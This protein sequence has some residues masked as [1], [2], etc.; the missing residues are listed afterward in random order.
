MQ[1]LPLHGAIAHLHRGEVAEVGQREGAQ[2]V[3]GGGTSVE[4]SRGH[5]GRISASVNGGS[6]V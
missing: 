3:G 5:A 1:R 4:E 2:F 6:D